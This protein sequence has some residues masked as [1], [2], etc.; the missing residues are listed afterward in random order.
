MTLCRVALLLSMAVAGAAALRAEPAHAAACRPGPPAQ[1]KVDLQFAPLRTDLTK[2]VAQLGAMPGRAPGPAGVSQGHVLGLTQARYGE[3][4]QLSAI[5]Q[6]MPDGTVCAQPRALLVNFG[7]QQ[8]V[9]LVARELP[10]DSCIYREVLAHEMRHVAVDQALV[11]EFA[12]IV[13]RRLDDALAAAGPV[14]ARSQ[15]QALAAIRRPVEAALRS[16]IQEFGRERDRR[17]AEVDTREEYERV[18]RA[19]N[20]EVS[21]YL[22][23]QRR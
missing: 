18:S 10:P 12:P 21:R 8:H 2:S 19:C 22:P 16:T 15:Q 9:V 4:S 1:V 7:I 17:Q 3:Q 5:F 13:R 14:H 11:R 23:R 6:A 20:G